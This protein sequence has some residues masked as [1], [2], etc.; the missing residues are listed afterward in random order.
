MVRKKPTPFKFKYNN[1]LPFISRGHTCIFPCTFIPAKVCIPSHHSLISL[2]LDT[3]P[4]IT[5][6][7]IVTTNMSPYST[8]FI[9]LSL[10]FKPPFRLSISFYQRYSFVPKSFKCRE[11][12]PP[13]VTLVSTL[14][15]TPTD[16]IAIRSSKCKCRHIRFLCQRYQPA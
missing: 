15:K 10:A 13:N 1:F 9:K 5:F 3:E 2:H 8:T 12:F 16:V 7:V 11:E 4:M 6:T 14:N